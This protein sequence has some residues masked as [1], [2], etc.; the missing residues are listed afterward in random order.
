M[1]AAEL[2]VGHGNRDHETSSKRWRLEHFTTSMSKADLDRLLNKA[3]R[4]PS[5]GGGCVIPITVPYSLSWERRKLILFNCFLQCIVLWICSFDVICRNKTM[6]HYFAFGNII[7]RK[8][9][10]ETFPAEAANSYQGCTF[11]LHAWH[12]RK[13]LLSDW[14]LVPCKV[15]WFVQFFNCRLFTSRSW[16]NNGEL[17][18]GFG[19]HFVQNSQKKS[20]FRGSEKIK[21]LSIISIHS[22]MI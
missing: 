13:F 20:H 18:C 5:F 4:A 3:L 10:L 16:S 14:P 21:S 2:Y 12:G 9:W 11:L 17:L 6:E 22:N 15:A 7:K 19:G 8:L 1:S